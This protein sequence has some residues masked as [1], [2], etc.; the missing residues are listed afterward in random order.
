MRGRSWLRSGRTRQSSSGRHPE[1]EEERK[2]TVLLMHTCGVCVRSPVLWCPI[3]CTNTRRTVRFTIGG[4][5]PWGSLRPP[6]V[7]LAWLLCRPSWTSWNNEMFMLSSVK[8]QMLTLCSELV[9]GAVYINPPKSPSPLEGCFKDKRRLMFHGP[10][11]LSVFSVAVILT[12]ICRPL[13]E[14]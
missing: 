5:L 2:V 9:S 6:Q 10:V 7:G 13:I 4:G 12:T 3:Y 11:Q 8:V 14:L 1:E